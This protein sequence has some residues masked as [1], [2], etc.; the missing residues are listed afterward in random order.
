MELQAVYISY[1]E[2]YNENGYDLLHPNMAS[3]KLDELKQ[4][5]LYSYQYSK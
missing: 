1:L 3:G 4:A 5:L 2:I